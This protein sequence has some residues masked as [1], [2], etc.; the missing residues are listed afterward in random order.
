M[1][2]ASSPETARVQLKAKLN[3]QF[4]YNPAELADGVH[5]SDIATTQKFA[6]EVDF[7][8]SQKALNY[9]KNKKVA[10]MP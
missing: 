8:T 10:L 2:S 3:R 6:D 1:E 9:N 5:V 4:S 7:T